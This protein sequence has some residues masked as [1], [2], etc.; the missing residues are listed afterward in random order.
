MDTDCTIWE[1][2]TSKGRA[3]SNGGPAYRPIYEE[4]TGVDPK[5]YHLHHVCDNPM[6]V[7]VAHLVPLTNGE[8]QTLHKKGKL[9]THCRRGH[10]FTPENSAPNGGGERTCRKCKKMRRD[11]EA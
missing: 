4:E 2:G 11:G 10:E 1:G 6:C 7:N 5:G 8:H 3:W 9:F